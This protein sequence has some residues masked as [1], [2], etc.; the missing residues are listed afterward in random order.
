MPHSD[1]V[2]TSFA[3]RIGGALDALEAAGTLPAGLNRAAI[4]LEPPRDASHGDLSTNAAMVL[5][6]DAGKKPRDL[7]EAIANK[8]RADPL[9]AKVDV[10]GYTPMMLALLLFSSLM[11]LGLGIVGSYVWRA[12]ENTKR[13]PGSIV[14]VQS[15]HEPAA[16]A[17]A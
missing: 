10:A 17:R 7:A 3:R 5:A 12:Y 15:L 16:A 8:L 6:K 13:R 1:T 2:Y 4:T 14:L 9:I 11:L